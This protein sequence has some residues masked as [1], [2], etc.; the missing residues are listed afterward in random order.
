MKLGGPGGSELHPGGGAEG[1]GQP[2]ARL[3]HRG[4]SLASPLAKMLATKF[5]T[6]V[7]QISQYPY[8]LIIRSLTMSIFSCV[9]LSTTL[10]TRFLS[11]MLSFWSSN[12]FSSSALCSRSLVR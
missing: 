2:R 10:E 4:Q 8:D 5:N 7:E 12:S 3:C 11:L 6:S 1:A 9:S